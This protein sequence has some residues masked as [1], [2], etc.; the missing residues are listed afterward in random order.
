MEVEP[1]FLIGGNYFVKNW[2]Q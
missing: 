2:R 1:S